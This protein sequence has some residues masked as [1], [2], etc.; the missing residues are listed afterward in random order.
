MKMPLLFIRVHVIFLASLCCVHT[1]MFRSSYFTISSQEDLDEEGDFSLTT[2]VHD[3][4]SCASMCTSTTRCSN[5]LFDKDSKKCSLVKATKKLKLQNT[6]EP[7]SEKILL[8]KVTI[9]PNSKQACASVEIDKSCS[10]H[11]KQKTTRTCGDILRENSSS[12]TGF[13]N[14]TVGNVTWQTWCRMHGIIGCGGGV[15]ELVMRIKEQDTFNYDSLRWSNKESFNM[16]YISFK[17]KQLKLPGYWLR[18]FTKICVTMQ[19]PA[20]NSRNATFLL[21]NHTAQS[22][23]SVLHDGVKKTLPADLILSR[24]HPT[25]TKVV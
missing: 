23:Y 19:F 22:L 3:E 9:A 6:E 12:P 13:H 10:A 15:W 24:L 16:K 5:A 20:D 25:S 18:N 7:D 1:Q 2:N 11:A 4:F 8:E 21:V 17:G 14:I